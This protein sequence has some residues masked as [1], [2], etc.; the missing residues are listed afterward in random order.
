MKEVLVLGIGNRL[1]MDDGIG[2]YVVEEL[3]KRNTNP[4]IRYVIGE[5]DI[6]YC[7]NYIKKATYIIVVDAACLSKEPGEISTIPLEQVFKNPIQPI[8]IHDSHLL[9][10]IEMTGKSIEG[11][12]FGIEPYEINYSFGL[13]AI[14]QEQ[15]FKIV[16]GIENIITSHVR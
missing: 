5:T 11:L 9:S 2:V 16:E 3:E 14:L 15:F 4:D 12:F 6:Y 10:E 1:M 8:S 13:S 7:L